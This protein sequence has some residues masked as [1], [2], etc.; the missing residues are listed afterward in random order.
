[1]FT[2]FYNKFRHVNCMDY[3]KSSVNIL[4]LAY[5]CLLQTIRGTLDHYSITTDN[6]GFLH[7]HC[8]VKVRET[9]HHSQADIT[10]GALICGSLSDATR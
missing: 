2:Y 6:F 3:I 10:S 8:Y 1:M 7:V 5:F 4:L 9:R